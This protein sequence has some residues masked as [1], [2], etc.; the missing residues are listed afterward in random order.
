MTI[1]AHQPAY[2]PWLGYFDKLL[3]SDQFVFLDS[4]Q[5]E[6]NSF[7]NRNKIK[8]PQGAMW[9]TI[10]IKIKGHTTMTLRDIRIDPSQDWQG[11]HLRAIYLNYKKAPRFD[12]CYP[13]LQALYHS[14]A[15][16]LVDICWEH[17]IFWLQELRIEKNIICSGQLPITSAKSQ[18]I[19]DI[20]QY[21]GATH[22]LSGTLGKDY[23]DE[24][25]FK[26]KNI[27][28]QYQNYQHPMYPQLWGEFL[29]YMS[30]LDFWLNTNQ[31][32]LISGTS[33]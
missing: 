16:F 6:K 9:L 5:Y 2:L 24:Q 4:V 1:A 11:K 7:I 17:L 32:H 18:F 22:Y 26:E 21:L 28:I 29:P 23:L 10:P 25:S 19:L 15:E 27:Q 14:H 30:I 8:G 31:T 3:R 20:C 13:K 33:A 12:E